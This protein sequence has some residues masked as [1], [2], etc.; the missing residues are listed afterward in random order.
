[1]E[2]TM[3][4]LLFSLFT[5]EAM[6][7]NQ[8]QTLMN[9]VDDAH[10]GSDQLRIVRSLPTDTTLTITQAVEILE[11]F[12]FASEQ[13]TALEIISPFVTDRAQQYRIIE[14]FTFSSDKDKAEQ[15]L[16]RIEPNRKPQHDD[17]RHET[18][19][20]WDENA[21]ALQA[22]EAELQALERQLRLKEQQLE[23]RSERLR[24][25]KRHLDRWEA[26]LQTWEDRLYRSSS[27]SDNGS[28]PY[29]S[30]DSH[31]DDRRRRYHH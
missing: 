15:I 28:Q 31:K 26:R 8:F 10:F 22:K 24:E 3:W 9:S 14:T 19:P 2:D 4:M 25:K 21:R 13:L 16:Q 30:S 17:N 6:P 29:G 12:T 5:A 20:S 18:R 7:T 1:M 23:E 11:S 27:Y